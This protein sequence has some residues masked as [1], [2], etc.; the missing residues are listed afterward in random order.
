MIPRMDD[1]KTSRVEFIKAQRSQG[2]TYEEIGKLL[3][4]S[5]QRVRQLCRDRRV[6]VCTVCGGPAFGWLVCDNV[7]CKNYRHTHSQGKSCVTCGKPVCNRATYCVS[8]C[9]REH[10]IDRAKVVALYRG[11]VSAKNIAAYY[12]VTNRIV[13]LCLLKEPKLRNRS[14]GDQRDLIL[15]VLSEQ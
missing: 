1:F 2:K 11:G 3:G 6:R 4:V 8:C 13:Y 15:E 12:G 7:K 9:P 10:K 5:K 14:V